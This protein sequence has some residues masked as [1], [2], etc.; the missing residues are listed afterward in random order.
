MSL[1]FVST[2]AEFSGNTQADALAQTG[3]AQQKVADVA[4]SC[5]GGGCG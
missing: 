2:A 5:A 4:S 1:I 3:A